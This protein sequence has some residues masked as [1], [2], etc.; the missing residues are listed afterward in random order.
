LDLRK[1][2]DLNLI[3]A[4]WVDAGAQDIEMPKLEGGQGFIDQKKGKGGRGQI[5]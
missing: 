4:V 2:G 5:V 1:N 3:S